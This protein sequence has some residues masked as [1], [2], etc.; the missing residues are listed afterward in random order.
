MH[1]VV[2]ILFSEET[3]NNSNDVTGAIGTGG[4]LD[5]VFPLLVSSSI[6]S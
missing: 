4:S 3:F 5:L 6:D 2:M 1:C